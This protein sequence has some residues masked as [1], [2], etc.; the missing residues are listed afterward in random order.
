MRLSEWNGKFFIIIINPR[1]Q[2]CRQSFAPNDSNEEMLARNLSKGRICGQFAR[3]ELGRRDLWRVHKTVA[4][5][6]K[7]DSLDCKIARLNI[8]LQGCCEADLESSRFLI[9]LAEHKNGIP[10]LRSVSSKHDVS[11][12]LP[13]LSM[14]MID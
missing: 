4:R 11:R 7:K 13:R 14:M 6:S 12:D 10:P 3:D 8:R 5:D 1:L 2:E 9:P